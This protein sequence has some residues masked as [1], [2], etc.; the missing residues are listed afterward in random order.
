M[1]QQNAFHSSESKSAVRHGIGTGRS[2]EIEGL[3]SDSAA[4]VPPG[5]WADGSM[6][7]HGQ[8]QPSIVTGLGG[9]ASGVAQESL[10]SKGVTPLKSDDSK[11]IDSLFGPSES[12]SVNPIKDDILT[13]FQGLSLDDGLGSDMWGKD[14]SQ[15]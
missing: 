6:L 1:Y 13:G 8:R 7:L 11:M 3:S 4:F 2:V 12:K 9:G 5:M 15:P 14:L 10:V